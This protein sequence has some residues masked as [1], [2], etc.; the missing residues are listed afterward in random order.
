MN[1]KQIRKNNLL[2]TRLAEKGN[3]LI[4]KWIEWDINNICP[5][6]SYQEDI[7]QRAQKMRKYL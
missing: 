6:F 4:E 2:K 1:G 5:W 3:D 7:P